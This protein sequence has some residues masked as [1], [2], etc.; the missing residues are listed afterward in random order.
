MRRWQETGISI[1]PWICWFG[2]SY[3]S[4]CLDDTRIGVLCQYIALTSH[5]NSVLSHSLYARDEKFPH[6]WK[7]ICPVIQAVLNRTLQEQGTLV[8]KLLH[9]LLNGQ[10]GLMHKNGG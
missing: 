3:D 5:S 6:V 10:W 7:R 9:Q 4:N 8:P 1:P 2:T